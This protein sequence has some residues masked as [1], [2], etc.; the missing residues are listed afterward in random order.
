VL[1]VV[2]AIAIGHADDPGHGRR[3]FAGRSGGLA[4]VHGRRE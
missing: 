3:R 2:P 1:S 4:I